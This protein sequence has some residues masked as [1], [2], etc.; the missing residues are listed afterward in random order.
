MRSIKISA[1]L[2]FIL[3]NSI[4]KITSAQKNAPN[5]ITLN[6]KKISK[7]AP[8]RSYKKIYYSNGKMKEEGWIENGKKNDFWISYFE[9]GN[10]KSEG[11]YLNDTKRD[12]W[13]FYNEIGQK[14]N[15]GH[16]TGPIKTGFHHIY[17]DGKPIYAG[18]FVNDLKKGTW[19]TLNRKGDF[20][21]IIEY[22]D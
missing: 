2:C 10:K 16:Y 6:T 19:V 11:H 21:D 17:K 5:N 18:H 20:I 8:K 22:G 3:L 13:V 7:E 1:F 4:S 12:W 9:N 14:T 15:E